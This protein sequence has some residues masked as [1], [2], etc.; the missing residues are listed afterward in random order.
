ME[1]QRRLCLAGSTEGGEGQEESPCEEHTMLFS[2]DRCCL[3]G[4]KK[5]L[6]WVCLLCGWHMGVP[7]AQARAH[8]CNPSVLLGF[9][10]SGGGAKRMLIFCDH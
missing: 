8:R 7:A 2:Q 3:L 10:F 9:A 5:P 1:S 4:E 6:C